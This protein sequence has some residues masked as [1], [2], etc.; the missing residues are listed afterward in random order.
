MPNFTLNFKRFSFDET[1]HLN[2]LI[3][4]PHYSEKKERLQKL[5]LDTN[6]PLSMY[7]NLV[8]DGY[9]MVYDSIA[10][11]Y[12]IKVEDFEGNTTIIDL[13]INGDTTPIS[14]T[15]TNFTSQYYINREDTNVY[16]YNG[17]CIHHML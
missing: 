9:V 10:S 16:I 17:M 4:Y 1:K 2:R 15:S 8:D 6:N 12:K 11:L 5:F 14:E 7:D 3:D 13:N